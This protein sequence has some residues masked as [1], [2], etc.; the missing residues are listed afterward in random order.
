M[1]DQAL[2]RSTEE[3]PHGTGPPNGVVPEKRPLGA[4]KMCGWPVEPV[5]RP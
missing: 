4:E 5:S 3:K 2:G 1:Q